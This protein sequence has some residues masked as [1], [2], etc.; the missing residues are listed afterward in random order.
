MNGG[1]GTRR[2]TIVGVFLVLLA[3]AW[4]QRSIQQLRSELAA[5]KDLPAVEPVA[6]PVAHSKSVQQLRQVSETANRPAP[7]AVAR[8]IGLENRVAALEESVEVL[9]SGANYLMDRGEIPPS[10]AKVAELRA[11]FLDPANSGRDR[12]SAL[13]LLQRN[14]LMDDQVVA[15]ASELLTRSE[16]PNVQR[17]LLGYLRGVENDAVKDITLSLALSSDNSRVRETA[18]SN[19]RNLAQDPTVESV[20]WQLATSD[21]SANVRRRAEESLRRA[22]LTEQQLAATRA[23]AINSATPLDERLTAMRVLNEKREDL[24]QIAPL[25]AASAQTTVDPDVLLKYIRSFDDV[26]HPEFMLPLV[27]GVQ[28]ENTEIR[29]RATDALIDYRSDPTIMEW[30][31]VLAESDPD[32]RVRR[33]ASRAFRDSGREGRR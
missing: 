29:L 26:N 11:K 25:L 8:N 14:R 15:T 10:A 33:E 18:L 27:N 31:T 12:L 13:R 32:P 7:E 16:D 20:L 3:F 9:S 28:N 4:Q 23:R 5:A 22:D 24:S 1:T 2:L 19:L 17:S 21:P 6:Q 30:L